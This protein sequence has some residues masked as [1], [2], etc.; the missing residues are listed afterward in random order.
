MT[1][2]H[3]DIRKNLPETITEEVFVT[4]RVAGYDTGRID[5]WGCNVARGDSKYILLCT[6]EITFELPQDIDVKGQVIEGLE[7]EKPK[8]KADFHMELK[9]VQNKIDNLLAIEYKQ[10]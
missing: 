6:K 4:L 7:S 5:V 8:I 3:V 2:T 10:I 9:E 1:K